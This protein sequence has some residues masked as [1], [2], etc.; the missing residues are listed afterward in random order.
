MVLPVFI[1]GRVAREWDLSGRRRSSYARS[2]AVFV[3]LLGWPTQGDTLECLLRLRRSLG[4]KKL[5]KVESIAEL[6]RK[7]RHR[8]L[9][10]RQIRRKCFYIVP[11]SEVLERDRDHP[12]LCSPGLMT[13]K[14]CVCLV[15]RAPSQYRFRSDG[16]V[17][18][19]RSGASDSP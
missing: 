1:G 3:G 8:R 19:R 10:G 16:E 15:Q 12:G 13:P 17:E 5:G 2:G 6:E 14:A 7:A 18:S 11:V 4:Q 9:R